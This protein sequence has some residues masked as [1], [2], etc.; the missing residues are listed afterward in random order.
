MPSTCAG[1][2][3]GDAVAVERRRHHQQAKV[4]SQVDAGVERERQAEVGLEAAVNPWVG[5]LSCGSKTDEGRRRT[6]RLAVAVRGA[7][8]RS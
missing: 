6:G 3:A 5:L 7:P 1:H 4:R 2:R 8:S